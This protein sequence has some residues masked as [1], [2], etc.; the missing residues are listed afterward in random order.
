MM[1]K[2]LY[3]DEQFI[4][5]FMK[6]LCVVSVNILLFGMFENLFMK[7]IIINKKEKEF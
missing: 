1:L 5:L 2:F 6:F 7:D 4:M 3:R